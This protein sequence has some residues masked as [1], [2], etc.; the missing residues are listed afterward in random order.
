MIRDNACIGAM[1]AS[2]VGGLWP[3]DCVEL[4]ADEIIFVGADGTIKE[5]GSWDALVALNG[6]FAD[7][8]RIQSLDRTNNM[9]IEQLSEQRPSR[10]AAR[11]RSARIKITA[12]ARLSN[13]LCFA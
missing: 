5:Q 7:F 9:P 12:A 4:Q 3:D 2:A 1:P 10:G 8:V 13:G 6:G 11:W